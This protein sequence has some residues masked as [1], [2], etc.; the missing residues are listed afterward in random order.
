MPLQAGHNHRRTSGIFR[1]PQ[2]RW[3]PQGWCLHTFCRSTSDSAHIQSDQLFRPRHHPSYVHM[4]CKIPMIYTSQFPAAYLMIVLP[5][6]WCEWSLI[7]RS[8]KHFEL[9]SCRR[10]FCLYH[11]V[12][13]RR[14]AVIALSELYSF[15]PLSLPQTF[16]SLLNCYNPSLVGSTWS[17]LIAF[18]K[19]GKTPLMPEKQ[20]WR[21]ASLVTNCQIKRSIQFS[22]VRIPNWASSTRVHHKLW[23]KPMS[24]F[25][26]FDRCFSSIIY[27]SKSLKFRARPSSAHAQTITVGG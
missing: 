23:S 9:F 15:S 2:L 12:F 22:S 1:C 16:L 10:H 4:I 25:G 17:T 6:Y 5:P 27:L 7:L 20:Q 19:N 24:N 14:S 3:I 8:S 21:L 13:L 11:V 18:Q 26:N